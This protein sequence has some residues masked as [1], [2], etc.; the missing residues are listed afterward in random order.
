MSSYKF[1]TRPYRHQVDALKK[2]LADPCKHIGGGLPMEMGTGKTKVGIDYAA[3]KEQKGEI[4]QVLVVAPLSVLGVW[5]LEIIKHC[6]SDTLVW[7]SINYDKLPYKHYFEQLASYCARAPTLLVLDE[8]H[9]IKNPNAKRTKAALILARLCP[10]TLWLSGTPIAKHP[11]D[12]FA[13]MKAIDEAILGGSWGVFRRTYGV[14]GGYGGY[15]LIKYMNL[16]SLRARID[17]Y[18]FPMKKEDCLDLPAKTHQVVPVDLRESRAL[19]D[20]VARESIA[21]IESLEVETPIVLTRL[22]RLSQLT[23]GWAHGTEFADSTQSQNGGVS[24]E[25]AAAGSG[26]R[27]SVRA[28]DTGSRRAGSEKLDALQ[29]LMEEDWEE[30]VLK[31][32]IFCRF[33][34]ELKD[35]C[36]LSQE[37]GYRVIPFHGKTPRAKRDRLIA[38][39]DETAKPTVFVAQVATGSLGISLTAASLCTFFSHTYNYAQFAQACDR[40]HR[41]GQKHPVLYRHLL[42]RDTVDEAVW[43]SLKTKRN[44][45]EVVMHRPDLI[46]G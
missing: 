2:L 20:K 23:G 45:A 12:M 35:I 18:I 46:V 29:G 11:L 21:Y 31:Q 26:E 33:I 19:Y 14:W 24:S 7:K 16:K 17:P 43:L 15:Q 40:L 36:E 34:P 25:G 37:I 4:A 10:L 6:P 22:L 41:I 44:V 39:F 5:D 13:P 30:D 8:S 27:P 9:L 3:I 1:K 38:L 28:G 42:A 32:V